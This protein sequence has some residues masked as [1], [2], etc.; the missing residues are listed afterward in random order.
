VKRKLRDLFAEAVASAFAGIWVKSFEHEDCES[1][2]AEVCQRYGWNMLTWDIDKGLQAPGADATAQPTQGQNA[3]GAAIKA[4]VQAG[5]GKNPVILVMR[6]LHLHMSAQGRVINP[7]LLQTVQ[8]AIEQGANENCYIVSLAYDGVPIP[9]EL[10]KYFFVIDHDLPDSDELWEIAKGVENEANLP[11]KKSAE[12]RQ[13]MDAAAGLTRMEAAGAFAQSITRFKKLQ[14]DTLWEMKAQMLSKNGLLRMHRSPHGFEKLGGLANLK[15]FAVSAFNSPHRGIVQPRGV[16][17]VGIPGAGKSAFAKALGKEVGLPTV[18]LDVG[19]LKGSL[20]GQTEENARRALKTVDAMAPCVLMVDEIEKGLAGSQSG[21]HDSGV[22]AGLFGTLLTWLNDH[23]SEVFFIGTA[24]DVTSLPPEFTRAERFDALFF[25]DLPGREEKNQIWSI[26]RDEY[27]LPD[28][29]KLPDDSSWTGAEIKSCCRLAKLL[30]VSLEEAAES[31]VPIVL[32]A[33]ERITGLK[34]WA[35]NRCLSA[36]YAG[37]YQK[38]GRPKAPQKKPDGPK[39]R[40]RVVRQD[41]PA[42]TE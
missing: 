14:P 25:Y 39:K 10:E 19:A 28:T 4:L 7:A 37:P 13:I 27:Q 2:I 6:N 23:E 34:E 31:I 26:Y 3:P 12:A 24:N 18:I 15:S 42:E 29:E 1:T 9:L 8:N 35:H 40:R 32:T 20:V 38:T 21:G 5:D 41:A 33:E 16:I 11:E 17:L 36:D 22:S 30:D